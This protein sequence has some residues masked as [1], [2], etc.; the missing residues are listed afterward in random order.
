ME[1]GRPGRKLFHKVVSDDNGSLD[2]GSCSES[3]ER[4][5]DN[6]YI[7]NVEPKDFDK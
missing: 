4:W 3:G 7:V 6:E 5:S 2:Q 1:V